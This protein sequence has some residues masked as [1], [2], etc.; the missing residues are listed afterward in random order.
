MIAA[1]TTALL[2]C[3]LS[4]SM[5]HAQQSTSSLLRGV[6]L[7]DPLTAGP[8]LLIWADSPAL[9]DGQ[10]GALVLVNEPDGTISLYGALQ[11][12]EAAAL[13]LEQEWAVDLQPIQQQPAFAQAVDQWYRTNG[14]PPP[15]STWVLVHHA[16][17]LTHLL[18]WMTSQPDP[19]PSGAGIGMNDVSCI[20]N[21]IRACPPRRPGGPQ[22]PAMSSSCW[23]TCQCVCEDPCNPQPIESCED[24]D[25]D[26]VSNG[27]DNCPDVSNDGQDDGDGDG[28]G[29]ACDGSDGDGVTDDQDSDDNGDGVADPNDNCPYVDNPDQADTDGDGIGD[30]CD[31]NDGSGGGDGGCPESD[32]NQPVWGDLTAYR[33]QHALLSYAPFQRHAVSESDEQSFS[34][35]PGIRINAPGDTD[36]MGE[37]DLI[38]LDIAVWPPGADV[39]LRRTDPALRVWLTANKAPGS[40]LVFTDDRTPRL[41]AGQNDSLT[42]W[43]EW[44]APRHGTADLVLETRC[45]R[46]P[47]DVV[48]FHTFRSIVIALGGRN[49]VPADPPSPGHGTFVVAVDLYNRGYDVWMYDEDAVDSLGRGAAYNEVVTGIVNRQVYQVAAFG[50]SHGGGSV[51]DLIQRLDDQRAAIQA[52]G[53]TFSVP[54]TAYVDAIT[55][56]EFN[57]FPEGDLPPSSV[58]HLNL[59]QPYG[60]LHGVPIGGSMPPPSGLDVTGPPLFLNVDHYTIDDAPSV[61]SRVKTD[62][63]S[64]VDR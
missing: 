19:V 56:Q 2:A 28:V 45:G 17:T 3:V 60:L 9:F 31:P 7:E 40:Q 38:E 46:T 62:L 1:S 44:A 21:C 8:L 48:R 58:Y 16:P 10:Y 30:A 37:D 41:L 49:Q 51:F 26:G 53:G 63:E 18:D 15:G 64:H 13:S 39:V 27:S 57:P 54:F 5:A 11:P 4:E 24:D 34:L 14:Y 33:P 32:P 50:H 36:P 29:D 47:L 23:R 43:V 6:Q 52:A 61:R 20:V 35:G 55:N 25:G 12:A 59:Y 42:V 22:P